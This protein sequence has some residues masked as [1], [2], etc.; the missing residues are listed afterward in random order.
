[1]SLMALSYMP[2]FPLIN[3]QY[4]IIVINLGAK[5]FLWGFIPHSVA[6]IGAVPDNRLPSL[7]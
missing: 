1:M 5:M 6:E 3:A 7:A 4:K 2:H